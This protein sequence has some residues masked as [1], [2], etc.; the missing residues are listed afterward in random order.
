MCLISMVGVNVTQLGVRGGISK[1]RMAGDAGSGRTRSGRSRARGAIPHGLQARLPVDVETNI[2]GE[3]LGRDRGDV[4]MG[5]GGMKAKEALVES[6]IGIRQC[7]RF[8]AA[9]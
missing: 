9:R 1:L 8:G 6:V 4:L 2:A 5:V 3:L 7:N